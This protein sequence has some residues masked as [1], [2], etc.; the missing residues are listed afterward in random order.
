M[1]VKGFTAITVRKKVKDRADKIGA[2]IGKSTPNVL[3][4]LVDKKYDEVFPDEKTK[5]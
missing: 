3:A 5:T 1:P 2:I 4:D